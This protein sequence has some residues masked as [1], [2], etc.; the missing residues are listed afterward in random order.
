MEPPPDR[1]GWPLTL[2]DPSAP[3]RVLARLSVRQT[4]LGASGLCK[5]DH[6]VDPRTGRP[7]RG[8]L[9]AWAVVPRPGAAEVEA[10]A[11]EAPRARS[12]AIADALATAFMLLGTEEIAELCAISPGL[13][14]SIL[15][16]PGRRQDGPIQ[17]L[18]FGGP[19]D[20][21]TP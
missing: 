15:P 4:A 1:D 11:T 14:A 18:H 6:I 16:K 19:G 8:R 17:L 2:S 13:E 21:K 10:L 9:A 20:P 3:S 12:T 5:G 7:V